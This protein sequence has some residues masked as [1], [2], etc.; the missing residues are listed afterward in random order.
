VDDLADEADDVLGVV[1]AVGVVDDAG[2]LVGR[3]LVLVDDPF[4]RGAVAEAIFG[5]LGR[6]AAQREE[7]VVA[8]FGSNRLN[9]ESRT[10]AVIEVLFSA[11]FPT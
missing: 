11:R 10:L 3:E 7:G 4:E 8:E 5:D 2:A 9:S 6:G 1:F